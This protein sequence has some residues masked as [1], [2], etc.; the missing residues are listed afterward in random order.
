MIINVVDAICGT[1]KSTGLINMINEDNSNNKYLYITPFL[2]EVERIKISCYQK[3]FK[4][5]KVGPGKNKLKN[6]KELFKK[7]E[8]IVSTHALFRKITPEIIEIIKQQ[9]YILVMDEVADVL[10]T[11]DITSDDLKTIID[12]Y[13]ILDENKTLKWT[14]EKY[15][16]KFSGYKEIIENNKVIA[17]T[18]KK[19]EATAL[20]KFFPIEIFKAFKKMYLLTYMFDCQVQKYY[21]DMY[22]VEYKYWYIKDFHLTDEPQKYNERDIKNLIKICYINKLN[23]I[24]DQKGSLSLAWFDRNK[25][26]KIMMQLKNNIYNFF[27]NVVNIP[28]NKVLWTTFKSSKELM[29]GKGFA[30]S[31]VSLNIRATNQYS[32]RIAIAYMANRY[33]NPLIKTYFANNGIKVN[34]NRYALS[35]LIQFIFRS[36]IRNNKEIL[37]YL[38]S[39]RMRKLL[40]EWIDKE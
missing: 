16:G 18:N 3:H 4:E 33:L 27:R 39:S 20:I 38:P 5:P 36:A 14:A 26:N 7:G 15:E 19:G 8:N 13:V 37:I 1:G 30:K 29:K 11:L 24:G 12:K 2:T 10:D 6:I 23:E 17:S 25:N 32:D 31:F 35:E 40:Q 21:F 22:N 28:S 34:D 9:D